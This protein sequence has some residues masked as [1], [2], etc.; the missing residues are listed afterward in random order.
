MQIIINA[1]G[2]GTRLWPLSTQAVPK[3]FALLIGDTTLLQQTYNRACQLV[4]ESNIWI[5][6]NQQHQEL[7]RQQLGSTVQILIEPS[8]RDTLAAILSYTAMVASKTSQDETIIFLSSDHYLD[9]LDLLKQGL[10]TVD[11]AIQNKEYP[12]ILPATSPTYPSTNYGYIKIESKTNQLTPVLGFFEKP[13]LSKAQ[14][15][16]DSGQYLWNLGYFALSYSS[17]YKVIDS[18]DES[19]SV[20]MNNIYLTQRIEENTFNS[21]PKLSFDYAVLEK[22]NNLGTINLNLSTWDDIGSYQSLFQYLPKTDDNNLFGSHN[23][24]VIN[25]TNQPIA[26]VGLSNIMVI[27]TSNGLLIMDP[28]QVQ[29]IKAVAQ[30]HDK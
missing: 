6:V 3:Q 2:A 17:L 23:N 13:N 10:K 8:R 20:I 16:I 15:Y 21:I 9:E 4:P 14:E 1:G 22:T 19:L 27:N 29:H 11:Q 12:I 7:A 30:H 5:N 28:N 25:H 18:I 24:Q 26:I